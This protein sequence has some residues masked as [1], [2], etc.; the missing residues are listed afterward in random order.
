MIAGDALTNLRPAPPRAVFPFLT[1]PVRAAL[2]YIAF[3]YGGQIWRVPAGGGEA[4]PLTSALFYAT[5]PV[6]SADSRLIAFASMR[7]GNADVFV[8][9]AAGGD[10]RRLTFHSGKDTPYAFSPDGVAVYFGSARLGDAKEAL[11]GYSLGGAGQLYSV[12]VAGGRERLMIPLQ[13]LD[14]AP[15][16]DGRTLLYTSRPSQENEW[17]KHA[18]SEAARDIWAFDTTNATHRQITTFR[19]EDR[20]ALWSADGKTVYYLSERSGSFNVRRQPFDG[21]GEPVQVTFHKNHPVR[22]LSRTDNDDMVYG[23]DGEIWKLPKSAKEPTPVKVRIAQGTM[24]A[25]AFYAKVNDAATEDATASLGVYYDH[26]FTGAG[27][28]D[29]QCSEVWPGGPRR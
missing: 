29:H 8:M 18:V 24:L 13:A 17:R 20:D 1:P 28:A 10:I 4:L 27:D 3:V 21:G 22:F 6:W 19:G 11:G 16:P 7:H 5:Q 12:P 23:Y 15:S 26:T 9:P 14:V 2:Q 25:G